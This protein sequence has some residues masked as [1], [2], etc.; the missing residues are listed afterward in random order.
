MSPH[1]LGLA[2]PTSRCRSSSDWLLNIR[3][4]GYLSCDLQFLS[5]QSQ[6]AT[7]NDRVEICCLFLTYARGETRSFVYDVL[8]HLK[9]YIVKVHFYTKLS[10][11]QK[12][13]AF[14]KA[15][16]PRPSFYC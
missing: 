12:S 5:L 2:T 11:L 7:A 13:T 8:N 9:P 16:I 6:I 15:H 3:T 4:P 1:R 14:W 10:A